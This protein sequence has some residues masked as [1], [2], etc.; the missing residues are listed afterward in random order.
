[1]NHNNAIQNVAS[2]AWD[3]TLAYP[4]DMSEFVYHAFSFEVVTDIA[5]DAVFKVQ[6]APSSTGDPCVPGTFADIAATPT[7]MGEAITLGTDEEIVIPAGTEAGALC[8]AAIPC[9]QKFVQLAPVSGDTD[10]LVA[11][12]VRSG[13]KGP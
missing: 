12:H 7:C 11:F 9:R 3:G 5:V 10:N 8:S 2:R 1:M 13:P 4:A 6:S